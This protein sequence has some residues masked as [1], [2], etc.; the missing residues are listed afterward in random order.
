[1]FTPSVGVVEVEPVT[2]LVFDE[3]T[4][5]LLDNMDSLSGGGIDLATVPMYNA[6]S[7]F[8]DSCVARMV[9]G[10]EPFSFAPLFSSELSEEFMFSNSIEKGLEDVGLDWDAQSLFQ[11]NELS[12]DCADMHRTCGSSIY[13]PHEN[14]GG[15]EE[16]G[17]SYL[18]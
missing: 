5:M 15:L 2:G 7:N 4:S 11:S 12:T 13:T 16:L 8:Q 14:T 9:A 6:P 17:P 10:T 3:T 1:M 18:Q